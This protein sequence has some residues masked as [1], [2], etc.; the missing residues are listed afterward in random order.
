MKNEE[1]FGMIKESCTA[2]APDIL[3]RLSFAA[4]EEYK[5]TVPASSPTK[6]Y[7]KAAVIYA[8]ACLVLVIALPF[9]IGNVTEHEPTKPGAPI[10]EQ[11]K[12]PVTETTE[13][14]NNTNDGYKLAIEDELLAAT[15]SKSKEE[16][17]EHGYE[18]ITH[19]GD[20]FLMREFECETGTT[21]FRIYNR[22]LYITEEPYVEVY[23]SHIPDLEDG[24]IY[25]SADIWAADCFIKMRVTVE[26]DFP[27]VLPE[28]AE[29]ELRYILNIDYT[30]DIAEDILSSP[31]VLQIDELDLNKYPYT[32]ISKQYPEYDNAVYF[33]IRVPNN[34]YNTMGYDYGTIELLYK[35]NHGKSIDIK[36]TEKSYSADEFK[37]MAEITIRLDSCTMRVCVWTDGSNPI[38]LPPEVEEVLR[39]I[40]NIEEENVHTDP[41][42]QTTPAEGIIADDIRYLDSDL[43]Y[44]F[45]VIERDGKFGLINTDGEIIL[46]VVYDSIDLI[47]LA[48][49]DMRMKLLAT[50]SSET[51]YKTYWIEADGT[52][53]EE[54]VGGWGVEGGVGIYWMNGKPLMLD[55]FDGEIEYS[56]DRYTSD[57]GYKFSYTV[58]SGKESDI[59]PIQEIKE[60]TEDQGWYYVEKDDLVSRKYAL[61]NFRTKELITDFI[62]DDCG[63]QGFVEGVLPVKKDGKW[64]Y[65]NET[66]EM[67]TDF[68]YDASETKEYYG[69]II[70]TMYYTLNGYTIVRQGD[71][72][73]LMDKNGELVLDIKYDDISQVNPDGYVWVKNG[74]S[75]TVKKIS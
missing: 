45:A 18:E 49:E 66:G 44:K 50:I 46:A 73:G 71:L 32:D 59:I 22:E 8:A 7:I 38:V 29:K 21:N 30:L 1:M 62:F 2:T 65:V 69:N 68:I 55:T 39:Y 37:H 60:Y 53:V 26:D 61:F 42:P 11:M 40:L 52:P 47:H 48:P 3:P 20:T 24:K 23:D 58:A 31:G 57:M 63:D 70:E 51:E 35:E 64:G 4:A 54:L 27:I 13:P 74:S 56:V 72:F 19:G 34:D 36:V 14:P 16:L 17:I 67:I 9:I 10:T 5:N 75:W 28:G 12:P 41:P 43:G 6:S 25:L 33:S 15:S